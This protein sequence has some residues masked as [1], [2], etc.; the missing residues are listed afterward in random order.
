MALPPGHKQNFETLS[1]AFDA[2]DA[3]SMEAG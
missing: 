3:H 2:G 1:Q